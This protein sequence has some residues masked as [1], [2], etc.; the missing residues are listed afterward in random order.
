LFLDH[1]AKLGGGEIALLN[2]LRQLRLDHRE[3]VEPHVVLFEDGPLRGRLEEAGVGVQVLPLAADLAKA[4]KDNIGGGSLLKLAAAGRA[5][6]FVRRLRRLIRDGGYDLIYCN[7]LKSDVLGGIAGRLA[8]R[9]VVWHVRDRLT[10]DYLPA[11]TAAMMRRLASRVP[12]G[13]VANSRHTISEVRLPATKPSAVVYSGISQPPDLMPEPS[14]AVVGLVGR[15]AE[16]KGQHVFLEAAAAVAAEMPDVRFRLIGSAM[17][18]EEAYEAH[19]RERAAEPD[20]A[21]R[22]E[23]AGF[24]DDF[25]AALAE[26]TVVVHASVTP[27]PF[28]QVVVEAMAA[29]RAVIATDGGGVRETVLDRETGLLVP[30]G[31]APAMASAM[32][33][34]LRDPA[35]RRMLAVAG[36]R[37]ALTEFGIADTAATAAAFMVRLSRQA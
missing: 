29:G 30:M 25:W 19:L 20:L 15:L 12:H 6:N 14:Q 3:V 4:S 16:W 34:L 27:E 32:L 33:R 13:V 37:R 35:L 11:R 23:F 18:G 26:L 28:G 36:R 21:G 1:T 8:R 2:L 10:D 17:F 9:R 5:I 22:V 31:D 7:S 24:R